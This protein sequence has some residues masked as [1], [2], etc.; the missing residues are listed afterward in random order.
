[1]SSKIPK[2]I[3]KYR[4]AF[5]GL[6]LLEFNSVYEYLATLLARLRRSTHTQIEFATPPGQT[7][8][9]RDP[10]RS[11]GSTSSPSRNRSPMLKIL[12]PTSSLPHALQSP[13]G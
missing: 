3:Q 11:G 1:M 9:P 6:D 8:I 12:Q 10:N 7:T 4:K 13:N 2:V 5:R